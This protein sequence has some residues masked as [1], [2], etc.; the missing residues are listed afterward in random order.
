MKPI[1]RN[2]LE[3]L[4]LGSVASSST[5]LCVC[6][7]LSSLM[8]GFAFPLLSPFLAVHL[9][10]SL[11]LAIPQDRSKLSGGR[12]QD[13]LAGLE[14]VR[15]AFLGPLI[16]TE[17][18]LTALAQ[19]SDQELRVAT[20]LTLRFYALEDALKARYAAFVSAVGQAARRDTV[21]HG[22]YIVRGGLGLFLYPS[23]LSCAYVATDVSFFVSD[24]FRVCVFFL[25][26]FLS[27]AP[28]QCGR[29]QQRWRARCCGSGPRRR[30]RYWRCWWRSWRTRRSRWRRARRARWRRPSRCTLRCAPW[31]RGSARSLRGA[32]A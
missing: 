20:D 21:T 4:S 22:A 8:Y 24:L 13:R 16:P 30:T 5:Y 2:D 29:R 17:R 31:W 11:S 28:D 15:D 12:R 6:I 9:S 19:R 3:A 1:V 18:R 27:I 10:L 32:R 26:L 25:S 14:A 23:P 7:S